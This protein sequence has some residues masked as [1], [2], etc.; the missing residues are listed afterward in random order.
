MDEIGLGAFDFLGIIGKGTYGTVYKAFDKRENRLVAIKKIK[1]I[2]DENAGI[3]KSI[4]REMTI[5]QKIKHENIISLMYSFY[6]RDIDDIFKGQYIET[7]CLYMVFEYCNVDLLHFVQR[8]ILTY[9][10]IKYIVFEILLAISYMH[11]NN[12]IH[13]DIKPE[14]IFI[15]SDGKVKLGDLGMSVEMSRCMTP[16]VATLWYRSP[17][18]LANSVNYDQKIDMWSVG[19][20]FVELITGKPIFPGKNCQ[21]QIQLI[22]LTLGDKEKIPK[23]CEQRYNMFPYF[24]ENA[25]AT[26]VEEHATRD[27]IARMLVYDP[28]YRISAKE[29]LKHQC[30]SDLVEAKLRLCFD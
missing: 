2:C 28:M 19:C 17:E 16:T 6:A 27:L 7:Y 20:L 26:L 30:F 4:L 25:L 24:E 11:S 15:N 21:S 9:K 23:E 13:R 10:D 8:N 1:N 14:N 29:A 18:N 5:L 12:F 22:N 3:S